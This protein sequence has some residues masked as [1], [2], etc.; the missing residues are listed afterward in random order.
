MPTPQRVVE[1]YFDY[2]VLGVT[3]IVFLAIIAVLWRELRA[4]RR[5]FLA[6]AKR[7]EEAHA[8]EIKRKDE[9]L[10]RAAAEANLTAREV[11]GKWHDHASSMKTLIESHNRRI[12][13]RE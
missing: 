13:R 3:T 5:D 12:G 8:V 2:G 6:E 9:A 10:E 1:R 11:G 7:T 4:Q